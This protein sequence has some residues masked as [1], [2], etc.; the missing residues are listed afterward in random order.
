MGAGNVLGRIPT[1][2][3][4]PGSSSRG[5]LFWPIVLIL[6]ASDGVLT[7]PVGGSDFT[8]NLTP[9]FFYVGHHLAKNDLSIMFELTIGCRKLL[10]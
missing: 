9:E 3:P 8:G 1:N 6:A 5:E 7:A 4:R 2:P 10:F